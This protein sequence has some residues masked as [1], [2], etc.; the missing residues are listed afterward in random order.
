LRFSPKS[1]R[2]LIWR[3]GSADRRQGFALLELSVAIPRPLLGAN[4]GVL[5]PNGRQL[6]Y[7]WTTSGAPNLY[8]T[9]VDRAV[10]PERLTQS[11]NTQTVTDWSRDGRFLLYSEMAND[12]AAGTRSD[13]WALSLADHKA[14]RLMTTPAR[15]IH[16]QFSPDS[17][18]VAYTS[19]APGR[20]EI[21]LES[22]PPSGPKWQISNT[23][24]DYARWRS[25]GK[26]LY[27]IAP[28]G[29][30]VSVEIQFF[31][32]RPTLG[33]PSALFKMPGGP[34]ASLSPD[35][36]YDVSPDGRILALAPA[37]ERAVPSLSVV[38]GWEALVS[39]SQK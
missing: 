33:R 35:A 38:L 10:N 34:R 4:S 11:S 32:G 19:D 5:S 31:A 22:F 7:S 13:L 12:I 16:G 27:Y 17:K 1:S 36:P 18:W 21:F 39:G 25:D 28:D 15:E 24:G 37:M 14:L 30:L 20:P 8:T 6:A 23:G 29:N 26:E 9:D 3:Q 2:I